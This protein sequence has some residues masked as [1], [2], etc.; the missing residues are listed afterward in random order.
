MIEGLS[1][2]NIKVSLINENRN[3]KNTTIYEKSRRR[4]EI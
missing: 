2:Y 1:L 3:S 4:A